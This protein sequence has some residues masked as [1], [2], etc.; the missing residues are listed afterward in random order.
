MSTEKLKAV[1]I[2]VRGMG[3]SQARILASHPDYKL[4]A[5]CDLNESTVNQVAAE[6]E[7]A[8]Y[9]DAAEML[10]NEKPDVVAICTDNASH[11][12]LTMLAADFPIRAV[13]C[14]KPMATHL[15][16]ARAMVEKCE[17]QGIE[18]IINHQRRIGSDLLKIRELIDSGAIGDLLRIRASCAGD[19]LSDGTHAIDSSLWFAGDPELQWVIGSITRDLDPELWADK[20]ARTPGRIPGTRY[21]HVVENG[22]AGILRTETKVRIEVTCGEWTADRSAYQDYIIEG[23]RG[24]LWRPG[25]KPESALFVND[26]QPGTHTIGYTDDASHYHPVPSETGQ[27]PW[28]QVVS[29]EASGFS[30]IPKGYHLL[31]KRLAGGPEHPMT[32]RNALRGFEAVMGIYESARIRK[33]LTFPIEQDQFPLE[34]MLEEPLGSPS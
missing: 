4:C 6:T 10:R 16:D 18:L 3:R 9:L 25:D 29:K 30:G 13:Y 34:V 14:E 11:A 17:G 1:V 15:V 22:G 26:G 7:S 27:G 8:P 21:G 28:R 19:I 20:I 32:A 24:T 33:K 5:V 23:T 2:G 12:K 31:A